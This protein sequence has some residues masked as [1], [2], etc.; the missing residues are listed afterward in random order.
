MLLNVKIEASF[1]FE[2]LSTLIA[3]I[4]TALCMYSLFVSCQG[5]FFNKS[6]ATFIAM[7]SICFSVSLGLMNISLVRISKRLSTEGARK[8]GSQNI[9]L[10]TEM[11]H[12]VATEHYFPTKLTKC[13]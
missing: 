4:R 8:L 9:M 13:L 3:L 12:S 1:Q 7:K 6:L 2:E 11:P 5:M 10:Y